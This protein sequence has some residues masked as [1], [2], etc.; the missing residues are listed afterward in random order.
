VSAEESRV[1][2]TRS[3]WRRGALVGAYIG[4]GVV[5]YQITSF[6]VAF[7]M[8]GLPVRDD[9]HGWLGPT[10][11]RTGCV[12]DIGKV[13]YWNCPDVSLFKRHLPCTP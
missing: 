13:N 5:I 8:L 7:Q 10:P 4:V 3:R 11:G 9:T 12:I 6:I 2:A 1:E